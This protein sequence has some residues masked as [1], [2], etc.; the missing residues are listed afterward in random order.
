MRTTIFN[1]PVEI[2]ETLLYKIKKGNALGRLVKIRFWLIGIKG[3]VTG[4]FV[5]YRLRFRNKETLHRII[6][7]HVAYGQII[8]MDCWSAYVN[9]RS[10]PPQFHLSQFGFVHLFVDQK[11]EFVSSFSN[12]IH[13]NTMERVWSSLKKYIRILKPRVFIIETVSKIYLE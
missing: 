5:V 11:I 9:N 10:H 2:D 4:R 8:Y 1:E 7:R 13:I 6:L 12:N 3:R